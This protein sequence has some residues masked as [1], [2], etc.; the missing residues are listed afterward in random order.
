MTLSE[1]QQWTI[2][3]AL[4]L[5]ADGRDNSAHFLLSKHFP[6]IAWQKPI[7]TSHVPWPEVF[8]IHNES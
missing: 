4:E 1:R 5:E 8:R 6:G 3:I 2:N 7:V